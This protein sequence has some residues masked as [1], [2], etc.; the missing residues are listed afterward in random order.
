MSE[1]DD[2]VKK[3]TESRLPE[4]E[5]G[6]KVRCVLGTEDLRLIRKGFLALIRSGE[7]AKMVD[8]RVSD[9]ERGCVLLKR[10]LR[11]VKNNG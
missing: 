7:V 6:V 3:L 2:Y 10:M 4:I 1:Y 8:I 9:G 11:K 5:G